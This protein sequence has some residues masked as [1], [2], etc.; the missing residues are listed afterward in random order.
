MLSKSG[1]SLNLFCTYKTTYYICNTKK[2]LKRYVTS[3][4]FITVLFLTYL[5]VMFC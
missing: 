4:L 2:I 5:I 3:F 1:S